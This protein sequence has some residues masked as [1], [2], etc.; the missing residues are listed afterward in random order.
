MAG[1]YFYD[2]WMVSFRRNLERVEGYIVGIGS[3]RVSLSF[4]FRLSVK[5][6]GDEPSNWE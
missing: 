2:V 1:N 3:C 5:L 6:R 4:Y